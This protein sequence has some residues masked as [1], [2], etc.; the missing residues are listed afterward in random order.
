M[1]AFILDDMYARTAKRSI[2]SAYKSSQGK[3]GLLD[4]IHNLLNCGNNELL[5]IFLKAF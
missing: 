1:S 3:D 4:T 2:V 5:N